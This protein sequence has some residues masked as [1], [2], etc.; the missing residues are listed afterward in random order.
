MACVYL[1][2]SGQSH[3]VA[4]REF[5]LDNRVLAWIATGGLEVFRAEGDVELAEVIPP[6]GE[7]LQDIDQGKHAKR[8]LPLSESTS[9]LTCT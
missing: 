3:L 8:Y 6:E 4:V 5:E 9:Q 2:W 1:C 7:Y